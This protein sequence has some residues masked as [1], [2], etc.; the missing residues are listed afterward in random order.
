M[1]KFITGSALM[2]RWKIERHELMEI[3]TCSNNLGGHFPFTD[4]IVD[5]W[6]YSPAYHSPYR[7]QIHKDL[8]VTG[9]FQHP[10]LPMDDNHT[11]ECCHTIKWPGDIYGSLDEVLFRV[12][13]IVAFEK[14]NPKKKTHRLSNQHKAA[15]RDIAGKL[16]N[17]DPGMTIEAA[18]SHDA[19][20]SACG[21]AS[22][23]EATIRRWIK[24]LCPNRKPGRRPVQK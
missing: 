23:N 5:L 18:I 6:P 7:L 15:V 4:F 9:R 2:K 16:W 21:N 13:D 20:N 14:A 11:W 22:Y 8:H 1:E 10:P 17:D 3:I 12:C 19:V 24:D